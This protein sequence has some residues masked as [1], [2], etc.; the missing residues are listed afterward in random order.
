VAFLHADADVL[1]SPDTLLVLGELA[2]SLLDNLYTLMLGLRRIVAR[3]AV[4]RT[5]GDLLAADGCIRILTTV[6]TAPMQPHTKE[7]CKVLLFQDSLAMRNMLGQSRSFT[8]GVQHVRVRNR[9]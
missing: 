3:A 7:T 2:L 1:R 6:M 8:E 9:H 5:R 4:I